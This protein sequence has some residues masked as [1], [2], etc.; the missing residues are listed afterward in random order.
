MAA[1]ATDSSPKTFRL[2]K[3]EMSDLEGTTCFSTY[4]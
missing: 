3:Q 2:P 1:E 4:D